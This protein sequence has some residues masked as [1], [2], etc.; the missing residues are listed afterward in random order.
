MPKDVEIRL[1]T[2]KCA[3]KRPGKVKFPCDG[4]IIKGEK[5]CKEHLKQ[6]KPDKYYEI[7]EDSKDEE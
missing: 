5:Y 3:L 7:F 6:F 2:N 4:E 1:K